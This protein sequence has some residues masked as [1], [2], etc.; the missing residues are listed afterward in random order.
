MTQISP[1]LQCPLNEVPRACRFSVAVEAHTQMGDRRLFVGEPCIL[2]RQLF[3]QN[4]SFSLFK[5]T[6]L[7]SV[8]TAMA[9]KGH[10]ERFPPPRLSG[11]SA[12]CEETFA[13]TCGNEEDAPKADFHCPACRVG[14]VQILDGVWSRYVWLA[15]PR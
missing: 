10:F 15:E 8:P 11:L 14:T 12:F 1:A 5:A 4:S 13:G 9:E 7:G 3:P 2:V 6:C